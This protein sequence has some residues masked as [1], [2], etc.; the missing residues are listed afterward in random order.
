MILAGA[1]I[2][3]TVGYFAAAIGGFAYAGTS[4]RWLSALYGLGCLAVAA[5]VSV[6]IV[7]WLKRPARPSEDWHRLSRSF[8]RHVDDE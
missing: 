5:P 3:N 8:S 2:W 6:Y 7:L 4:N 1:A